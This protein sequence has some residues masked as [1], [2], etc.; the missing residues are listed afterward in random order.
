MAV[1][2]AVSAVGL[3][4]LMLL[5]A[6]TR[7]GALVA[8]SVVLG[9]GTGAAIGLTRRAGVV[10]AL[11]VQHSGPASRVHQRDPSG[12]HSPR[13][14]RTGTETRPSRGPVADERSMSQG[15]AAP[16]LSLGDLG[17]G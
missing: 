17:Y 3:A 6:D 15:H 9:A 11:P 10:A 16:M 14:R 13:S 1:G 4:G 5:D 7:L 2:Y 12:R 8:V